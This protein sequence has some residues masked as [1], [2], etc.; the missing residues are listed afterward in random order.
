[1]S[2]I[3]PDSVQYEVDFTHQFFHVLRTGVKNQRVDQMLIKLSELHPTLPS[4][5]Q[6]VFHLSERASALLA[7][8][9]GIVLDS[10]NPRFRP[11]RHLLPPLE[12]LRA[13]VEADKE[14]TEIQRPS[15]SSQGHLVEASTSKSRKSCVSTRRQSQVSF[16]SQAPL[17]VRSQTTSFSL[18]TNRNFG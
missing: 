12:C 6:S 18:L 14:F 17:H 11:P 2:L 4:W 3:R 16:R 9:R 1:M 7:R 5:V 8:Q 13:A 10:F 15:S